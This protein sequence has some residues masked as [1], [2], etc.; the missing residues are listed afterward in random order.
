MD[1]GLAV[2]L[3]TQKIAF[4]FL[5]RVS[6]ETALAMSRKGPIGNNGKPQPGS[7]RD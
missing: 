1:Q 4:A 5:R 3:I 7:T 6:Y 2:G